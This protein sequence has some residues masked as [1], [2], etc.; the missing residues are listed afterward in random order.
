MSA[1]G[2]VIQKE[3]RDAS[4]SRWLVGFAATFALTALALSLAQ[5]RSGDATGQGFT[6]TTAG[7]VNLCLLLVPLLA[8]TL[9]ASA[10]A[11][12]R[13]RGTLAS[14]LSQP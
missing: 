13:E 3:L 7:L 1:M 8:L 14:L 12:E 4:K 9:G 2:T 5:G 6:R 10:V 11:G